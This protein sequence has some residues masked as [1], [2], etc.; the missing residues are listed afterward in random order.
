MLLL[1]QNF[2]LH[3]PQMVWTI[4]M[5]NPK[6]LLESANVVIVKDSNGGR[7]RKPI[8]ARASDIKSAMAAEGMRVGGV[9]CRTP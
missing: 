5:N 4:S 2:C 9:V 1:C 8:S 7:R 6:T 3:T